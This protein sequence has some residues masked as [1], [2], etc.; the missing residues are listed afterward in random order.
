MTKKQMVEEIQV[1][2]AKAWKEL[3]EAKKLWGQDE[4]ITTRLGAQWSMLYELREALGIP[5]LSIQSLI[6]RDLVPA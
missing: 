5:A 2:E 3:Q 4:P 1:A 6:E